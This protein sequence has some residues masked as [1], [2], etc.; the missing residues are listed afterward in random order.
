MRMVFSVILSIVRFLSSGGEVDVD[1]AILIDL[2]G[3]V[4]YLV[5]ESGVVVIIICGLNW[6]S[7]PRGR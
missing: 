6:I 4:Y 5:E 2:Y 3:C 7:C 1:E